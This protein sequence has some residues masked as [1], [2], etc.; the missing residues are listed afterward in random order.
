VHPQVPPASDPVARMLAQF[1]HL[2]RGNDASAP[3]PVYLVSYTLDADSFPHQRDYYERV[4]HDDPDVVSVCARHVAAHIRD[5]SEFQ[6]FLEKYNDE[7]L[8]LATSVEDRRIF[9]TLIFEETTI[10]FTTLSRVVLE[11]RFITTIIFDR[12]NFHMSSW[13]VL[14]EQMNVYGQFGHF[15]MIRFLRCR[16]LEDARYVSCPREDFRVPLSLEQERIRTMKTPQRFYQ[17]LPLGSDLIYVD[18]HT[19]TILLSSSRNVSKLHVHC[20]V[21]LCQECMPPIL[22]L[23]S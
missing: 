22:P 12:V 16:F 19:G 1:P 8:V 7:D 6:Q 21:L 5:V 13:K 18:V 15:R 14:S 9:R 2:R 23:G 11:L 4:H 3:P 17:H 10:D 20:H